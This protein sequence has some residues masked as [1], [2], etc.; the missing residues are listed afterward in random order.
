MGCR[1]DH[2]HHN[3]HNNKH[4]DCHNDCLCR[5]LD[6][7]RGETV[8]IT[9]RSGDVIVG[10]LVRVEDCCV[11]IIEPATITPMMGERLTVIR[12]KDIESFSVALTGR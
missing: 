3:D 7:F 11:K 2:D 6:K 12:C 4:N 5:L 1:K 8:T 9:T 10:E